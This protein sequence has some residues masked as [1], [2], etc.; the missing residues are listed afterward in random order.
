M[1]VCYQTGRRP[2]HNADSDAFVAMLT[3]AGAEVVYA[4]YIGGSGRDIAFGIAV[5]AGGSAFITGYTASSEGTFPTK[6]G[7]DLTH[8]GGY[9]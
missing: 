3:P 9:P 7:P 8:N 5:D 6:V 4:G 1:P 2:R